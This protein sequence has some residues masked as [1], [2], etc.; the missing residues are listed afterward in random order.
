MSI[1]LVVDHEK[2]NQLI[3]LFLESLDVEIISNNGLQ[4][5]FEYKSTSKIVDE[6]RHVKNLKGKKVPDI[7]LPKDICHGVI[8]TV[9]ISNNIAYVLHA[10]SILKDIKTFLDNKNVEY[11]EVKSGKKETDSDIIK[12]ILSELIHDQSSIDLSPP[13]MPLHQYAII[14]KDELINLTKVDKIKPYQPDYLMMS[15]NYYI[16]DL[17]NNDV[18]DLISRLMTI[19]NMIANQQ[20]NMFKIKYLLDDNLATNLIV[21]LNGQSISLKSELLLRLVKYYADLNDVG[22]KVIL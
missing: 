11:F 3:N 15:K 19:N 22:L 10:A 21:R 17:V 5:I 8:R 20:L 6:L 7:K 1:A 12:R 13:I 9:M 16:Y 18:N 4:I 2:Y 14:N